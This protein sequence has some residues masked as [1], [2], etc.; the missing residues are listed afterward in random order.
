ME[1]EPKFKFEHLEEKHSAEKLER[2]KFEKIAVFIRHP[3]VRLEQALESG[4]EETSWDEL[5][6]KVSIERGAGHEMSKNFAKHLIQEVPEIIKTERGSREYAIYSSPIHRAEA[7]AKYAFM[8]LKSAHRENPDIPLPKGKPEIIENFAE[9]PM[10]YKKGKMLEI[11]EKINS[12]GKP[13]MSAMEEWFKSD[14][15]F[16]A[17]VFEKE[18]GRVSDGLKRLETEPTPVSLIFTHRLV[19]GFMLWLT[20]HQGEDKTVSADDLPQIMD[21][22][23]KLPYTSESEIGLKDGKWH[24]L[25]EGDTSHLKDK[26]LVKGTF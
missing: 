15:K 2:E 17:S 7:L 5:E 16:I 11:L 6:D 20:E 12:E 9:I 8:N 22:S 4:D 25:R 23:R 3:S 14:P 19:T 10:A 21:I 24:I 18:R 1:K 26:S 13:I